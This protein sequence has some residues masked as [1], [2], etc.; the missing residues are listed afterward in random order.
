[1][2]LVLRIGAATILGLAS[3]SFGLANWVIVYK[4]WRNREQQ[5]LL[6]PLGA[7]AGALAVLIAPAISVKWVWVPVVLDGFTFA[8]IFGGIM[9]LFRQIRK[10][11]SG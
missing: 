1:V 2:Y 11:G 7:L 8:A 10:G 4:F 9:R 5:S 6:P 3:L